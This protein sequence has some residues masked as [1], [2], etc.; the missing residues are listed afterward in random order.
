MC[1]H[2]LMQT[3]GAVR[4]QKL[5]Q[6]SKDKDLLNELHTGVLLSGYVNRKG[7]RPI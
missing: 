4:I 2:N 3:R 1:S 5:Q 7:L 6:G